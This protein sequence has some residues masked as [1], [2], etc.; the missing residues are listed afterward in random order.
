[1]GKKR[2]IRIGLAILFAALAWLAQE[3]GLTEDSFG[4]T[5]N[6]ADAVSAE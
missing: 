2:L 1:M 6:P 4:K 3:F 5:L